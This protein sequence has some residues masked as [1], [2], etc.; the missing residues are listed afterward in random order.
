MKIERRKIIDIEVSVLNYE[1]A[2]GKIE[3]WIKYKKRKYICVSAVHLLMECHKDSHLKVGV[4]KAGMVTSD[5]MPLVWVLKYLWGMKQ[6]ERVYGPDLMLKLCDL[7]ARKKYKI[8]LLGGAKGES[9]EVVD[10]LVKKFKGI[11]VVGNIN[12]PNRPISKKENEKFLEKINRSGANIV[13]V[14]LGCPLQEKWMIEN[15]EKIKVN[16]LIG[17]G[18][19]FDF[20][21]GRVPQAN[22]TIQK[23]GLEWLFRLIQDPKRLWYRY[24]VYNFKFI[25]LLLGQTVRRIILYFR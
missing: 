10:V 22:K 5:G 19:A 3:E 4:N 13:F 11:R 25:Y 7:S 1:L 24:T 9:G 23:F 14:G 12:T 16:V 18:A 20:I 21:A 2:L 8:F 6:A 15:I 17:V